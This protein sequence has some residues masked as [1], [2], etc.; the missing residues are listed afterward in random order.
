MKILIGGDTVPTNSNEELFINGDANELVG[1]SL[2][3]I[4][5]EADY[6]IC[7][8]ET[9]L[10]LNRCQINKCGPSLM[11]KPETVR[12]YQALGINLVTL[13]NNHILDQSIKGLQ[14]TIETLDSAGIEHIGA[15]TLNNMCSSKCLR[16]N[17]NSIAI[18]TCAEHE[19]SIAEEER[20]GANPFEPC[21]S[22]RE[23]SNLAD[24]HDYV[25]V[26]YHG[27]KECYRYP[28]PLLQLRCHAIVDSGA[29][30]VIC[31]HS[32]CIGCQ[33]Q[34]GNGTIIY[35]QGNF[36]FDLRSNDY[37]N[38]GMLVK[39]DDD[40]KISYTPMIKSNGVMRLAEGAE[41]D[42][43]TNAFFKRS[44]EIL[45]PGF[46][47]NNY[48]KFA[49]TTFLEY[50]EKIHG[51]KSVFYRIGKRL[52][53]D[54]FAHWFMKQKYDID[55]ILNLVNVLECEPHRE[56]ALVALKQLYD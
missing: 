11:A 26:L 50:I 34:Y 5:R 14:D 20:I 7:N 6:R 39:L 55:S 27:G 16:D 8:L 1:V 40:F 4:L 32:H 3:T 43:I 48:E 45:K 28:S 2:Y 19:F 46:V 23:I 51:K 13:A 38:S 12:G 15:G 41:A 24:N 17:G 22:L 56:T 33:E 42:A 47:K 10:T 31:Q 18:Y 52:L 37:W 35:G 53:G 49:A 30:L 54:K 21:V 29:D 25:I 36:I 9:P 44:E